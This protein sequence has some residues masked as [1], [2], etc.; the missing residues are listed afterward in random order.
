MWIER[1]RASSRVFV[2]TGVQYIGSILSAG[3]LL[4]T[5]RLILA[6]LGIDDFGLYSLIA[7]I[8]ALLSFIK[9]SLA[10]TIQRFLSFYQGKND[11]NKQ[12]DIL[13]NSLVI[14]LLTSIGLVLLL[15]LCRKFVLT[16]FLSID[17]SRVEAAYWVYNNMLLMLFF[18]MQSISY[19]AVLIA[20]ENIVYTFIIQM[21]DV[22][23]KLFIS[24]SLA[25]VGFDKLIYYACLIALV[26]LFDFVCYYVYCKKNYVE[27]QQASIFKCKSYMFKELFVFTGWTVYSI[28][29]IVGR[30][31]GIAILLNRFF[32]TALNTSYGIAQQV[33]GHISFLS[34]S[35]INALQPQIVKAEGAKDRNKM[36]QLSEMASK[37][38]F[39][40]FAWITIPSL[41]YMDRILQVWLGEIPDYAVSFCR[42]SLFGAWMDQFTMGLGVAN[43]AIGKI[44][45]YSIVTSTIKI[46]ALPFAYLCLKMGMSAVSVMVCYVFFETVCTLSRV[47][48][49]K[50][51]SGLSVTSFINNVFVYELIPVAVLLAMTYICSLFIPEHFFLVAYFIVGLF[52]IFSIYYCGLTRTEK[53]LTVS[54]MHRLKAR[55]LCVKK[56]KDVQQ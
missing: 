2:N 18:T 53:E 46:L 23:L 16:E 41:F 5:S 22:I 24:I 51:G 33:I 42:Y 35:L 25:Y 27:C 6:E 21:I 7:G 48:L 4:Y 49:L 45:I 54:F 52:F 14:T 29:C 37:L 47:L 40:L 55:Y 28:G 56:N 38:S 30:T 15:F 31:Q 1:D 12:C 9:D 19:F 44:K 20:H 32:G 13:N 8:I 10:S 11:L 17:K 39:L 50:M 34:T 43:R 26:P 36:V 3:I